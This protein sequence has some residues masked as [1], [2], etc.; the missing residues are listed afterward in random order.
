MPSASQILRARR[1]R[2]QT[3]VWERSAGRGGL[4]L[5]G[6]STFL[7]GLLGFFAALIYAEVEKG[8]PEAEDL[9]EVFTRSGATGFMP[10]RLYD[11]T[12]EVVLFE[13]LH[14]LAADRQWYELEKDGEGHDSWIVTGTVAAVDDGFWGNPGYELPD[15]LLTAAQ[16][17]LGRDDG[18]WRLTITQQLVERVLAPES[19][20]VDPPV[21]RYL[22]STMLAGRLADRY[23]KDQILEAYL[24]SAYYG[25]LAYGVDAAA[26]VYFGKHASDLT[27]AESAMLAPIPL[28]PESNPIDAPLVANERQIQLLTRMVGMGLLGEAQAEEAA[29]VPPA[30][31]ATEEVRGA[32]RL[33]AFVRYAWRRLEQVLGSSGLQRSGLTVRTSLD[34]DLQRQAECVLRT[35]LA[36]MAGG[37]L[38]EAQPASDGAPCVASGLLP[39]VRPGDVGV[40]H[41]LTDGAVVVMDP[42]TGEILALADTLSESGGIGPSEVLAEDS[43]PAGPVLMPFIYLAAFA[44]GY[45]PG[46]MVLDVPVEIQLPGEDQVYQVQNLDGVFHGPSL[47]RTAL[48]NSYEA[49]AVHTLDLLGAKSVLR[50]AHQMGV[51]TLDDPEVDYG[52]ILALGSG[53]ARLLDLSYAFGVIANGGEMAGAAVPEGLARAKFRSLDPVRILEIEDSF[54]DTV[55]ATVPGRK[56]V[57]SPQLAYLMVDVLSDEAARWPTYGQMNALALGWPAGAIA[58]TTGSGRDSWAIGFTPSHLAGVWVGNLE[59]E[60]MEG[61]RALNG[62]APVWHALMKY[63]GMKGE[64]Q[65]WL[66]PPGLNRLEVCERSGLLPTEY[67]PRV[68]EEIFIQGTEP[69]SYD[70]LYRSYRVNKETGRLATVLTPIEL[71]E[72]RVYMVPP[73]GAE[74]WARLMEIEQPPDEYDVLVTGASQN[75]WVNISFPAPLDVVA[76]TV[77]VRGD[78]RTENLDVFRLQY[79]EGLN[80]TRWFQI[81]EEGTQKVR[82]GLLGR[83][84]TQDLSGLFTLQ[85]LAVNLDGTV[86]TAAVPVTID[87]QPP[88][89]SLVEPEDGQVFSLGEEAVDLRVAASDD[90]GLDRV[91]IYLGGRRIASLQ[92][93]P[94]VASW[95]PEEAGEYEVVVLAYDK[96]GT[97]SKAG[98]ITI[99]VVP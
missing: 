21:I 64:K 60:A 33:S 99:R 16:I 47:M 26:L 58:G 66:A 14:P 81:G 73:P 39:P 44:G 92:N 78:A 19:Q 1:R 80:P 96:A 83:W 32:V 53:E 54:G 41:R 94:F 49:A 37:P 50:T 28:E 62:A 74:E 4:L 13:V 24:N 69:T 87:N 70:N 2:A 17:L 15:V 90:F 82:G 46:S 11:R 61:V 93:A 67:C 34:M 98:G 23:P 20:Q 77:F 22:R 36:R 5:L 84:N 63:V 76:G 65:G 97:A 43:R 10:T 71:V 40:D 75:P 7:I 79:G 29:A 3:K 51:S 42:G 38:G 68:V 59:G 27:P 48:A 95:W 86:E 30:L 35:H 85:L 8:L 52:P 31:R 9:E 89:V 72:E 25:N 88:Q 45:A 55:Y 18:E 57:L 12:G 91:D 6:L 56:L